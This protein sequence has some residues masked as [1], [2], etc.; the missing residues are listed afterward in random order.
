MSA[1]ILRVAQSLNT[2]L[3]H[4]YLD[5]VF[6][7]YLLEDAIRKE[8]L[9]GKTCIPEGT[10]SM[11]LNTW[12]AMNEKYEEKFGQMHKGMIEITGIPNYSS[13]YI[14]IGNYHTDTK[15][16][17]LTGCYYEL[18]NGDYIMQQ[19]AI[20][21]NRIYRKLVRNIILGRNKIVVENFKPLENAI[22]A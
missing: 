22:R 5:D 21:Y 2:T 3:S 9:P 7:C 12:G 10:Y 16:C 4:L 19:S 15:G 18:R 6:Q 8:K 13:V 17:P 11:N 20:A 14:H 1:K